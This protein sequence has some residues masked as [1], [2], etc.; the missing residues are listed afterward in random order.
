MN[1]Y[2]VQTD[3]DDDEDEDDDE[4]WIN[5]DPTALEDYSTP[6]DADDCNIDEYIIFKEVLAGR[7]I[8]SQ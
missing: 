1:F 7:S 4:D 5:E 6:L 8:H 2:F 3:G